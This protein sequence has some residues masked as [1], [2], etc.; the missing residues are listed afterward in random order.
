MMKCTNCSSIQNDGATKCSCCSMKGMLI[1]VTKENI[2]EQESIK[3]IYPICKNCGTHD[4]GNA[5]QCKKCHFPIHGKSQ[6]SKDELSKS[7]VS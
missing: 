2:T 3:S 6:A 1:P 5:K 7:K 4:T